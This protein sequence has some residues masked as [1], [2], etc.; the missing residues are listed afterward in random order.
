MYNLMCFNKYLKLCNH[1]YNPVSEHFHK[2]K[3]VGVT[4][5]VL[6]F[7]FAVN[8]CSHLQPQTTAYMLS[9]SIILPFLEISY[10]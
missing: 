2:L 4:Q 3:K 8:I 5:K 6:L 10:K 1:H 7:P 9:V